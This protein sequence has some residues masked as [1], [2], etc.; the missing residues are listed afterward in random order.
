M[1]RLMVFLGRFVLDMSISLVIWLIVLSISFPLFGLLWNFSDSMP[2]GIYRIVNEPIKRG[3]IVV[4]CL[5][6][7]AAKISKARGYVDSYFLPTGCANHLISLIKPVVAVAGDSVSQNYQGIKVNGN[8]V[9]NSAFL[10]KDSK[11]RL[12]PKPSLPEIVPKN[13]LL[14][15]SSY[16]RFSWDSRY[17]GF[18]P[19]KDIRAVVRPFLIFHQ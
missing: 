19:V 17:Y 12:M 3:S 7:E 13:Q 18:I 10:I 8:F 11:G 2:A 4:F 5:N 6:D 1:I 15:I 9:L 16:S 14:L